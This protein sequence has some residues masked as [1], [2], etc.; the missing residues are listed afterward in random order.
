MTVSVTAFTAQA[1]SV[2]VSGVSAGD[3]MLVTA[4]RDGSTTAPTLA[5]GFTNLDSGGANTNSHRT[6]WKTCAGGE[7]TS[8]TWTNATSVIV[9]IIHASAGETIAIGAHS[10]NGGASTSIT[11]LALTLT[12]TDGSSWVILHGAHRSATNVGTNAL[13]PS[14]VASDSSHTDCAAFH[15]ASVSSWASQTESVSANSGWRAEVVEITVT[16]APD[17]S[18]VG[19]VTDDSKYVNPTFTTPY[20]AVALSG[21]GTLA[22]GNV[23]LLYIQYGNTDIGAVLSVT[24]DGTG[25]TPNT[26]HLGPAVYNTGLSQ[27]G[28][29][30]AAVVTDTSAAN[31]IISWTGGGAVNFASVRVAQWTNVNGPCAA[32]NPFDVTGAAQFQT[33]PGAGTDAVTSTAI[34]P[35]TNGCLLAGVL[36]F[37]GSYQSNTPGTG[38]TITDTDDTTAQ[39]AVEHI[40]QITAAAKAATWTLGAAGQDTIAYIVAIKPPSGGT[41]FTQTLAVTSTFT[42]ALVAN[43]IYVRVLT[44][45]STFTAALAGLKIYG[46]VLSVTSTFTPSV[47]PLKSFFRTLAVAGTFSPGVGILKNFFRTLAVT[48]VFAPVLVFGRAFSRTLAV[49]STLASTLTPVMIWARTLAVSSTFTPTVQKFVAKILSVGSAFAPALVRLFF[50]TLAVGSTFTPTLVFGRFFPRTLAVNSV[51]T[52]TL[53]KLPGKVLS[54]SNSWAVNLQRL[55]AKTLSISSTFVSTMAFQ[56]STARTLAVSSTFTPTLQHL[57]VKVLSV[58]GTWVVTLLAASTH[59]V[60]ALAYWTKN[61]RAPFSDIIRQVVLTMP[62]VLRQRVQMTPGLVRSVIAPMPSVTETKIVPYSP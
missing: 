33:N 4:H 26:Y 8:G 3:I 37:P 16:P 6:A 20:P 46:R 39:I 61:V 1:T 10:P 9:S 22:V 21:V 60:A 30:V 52:V 19:H 55:I 29:M 13:S 50:K 44:V 34:T 62:A 5:A 28:I 49:T 56:R 18:E 7:T 31:V 51:T 53:T 11:W 47:V 27:G 17:W 36:M 54:V 32:G 12:V 40:S 35:A 23:L 42:A 38:W 14:G 58:T 48:S 2:A 24:D 41:L 59:I 57:F 15:S 43:A 25:G 45:T